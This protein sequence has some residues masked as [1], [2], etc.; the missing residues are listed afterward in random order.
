M[1]AFILFIQTFIARFESAYFKQRPGRMNVYS[2]ALKQNPR[3]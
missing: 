1:K 3:Q 2:T